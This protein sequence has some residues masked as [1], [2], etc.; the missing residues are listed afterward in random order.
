[1][2]TGHRRGPALGWLTPLMPL[3]WR[4]AGWTFP[5]MLGGVTP[6]RLLALG[7][8]VMLGAQLPDA[9]VAGP[10]VS[11]V[12]A[13]GNCD[14]PSSA[15]TARAFRALLAPRLGAALQSEVASA[16]PLGGLATRSLTDVQH[17]VTDARAE[18][19]RGRVAQAVAALETLAVDVTRLPP[20]DERWATERDVWTLLAQ[21]RAK[22]S[23]TSAEAAL[24]HIYRVD[25][26]YHPDKGLY[27]PSFQKLAERVRKQQARAPTNRLDVAVSPPGTDLYVDGRKLGT[28]PVTL[29]LPAGTYRIEAGFARRS[30]VRSVQVPPPPDLAPPVELGAE[31]E[32][33]LFADGGPCVEPGNE[34]AA[35]LARAAALLA[36]GRLLAVHGEAPADRRV[37]V[38]DEVTSNGAEVRQARAKL[39]PG[40]PETEALAGLAELVVSGKVV[41]GVELKDGGQKAPGSGGGEGR[42]QGQLLGTPAPGGFTFEAYGIDPRVAHASLHL[43]GNRFELAELPAHRTVIH[44]VTDDG[45]VAL[46]VAE[47]AHGETRMDLTLEQPCWVTGKVYDEAGR[48]VFGARVFAAVR[49]SGAWRATRTGPRGHFAFR[50]LVRGDY[51]LLAGAGRGRLSVARFTLSGTCRTEL[52]V[53]VV[54]RLALASDQEADA[55]TRP[56]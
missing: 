24:A 7:A 42:L 29:R 41:G 49:S 23:S 21:A 9:G 47:G 6:S 30:L 38:L 36:V 16:A 8:S 56:P 19:Y 28:A 31:V 15:I 22:S 33:S 25:P 37:L 2:V 20:T 52:P 34:R 11:A 5:A 12:V 10:Q 1:M 44:V 18:F 43:K 14:A 45:R 17:A 4:K 27:P 3:R 51:E 48:P 46:D 53:V 54:P 50:D 55:G 40:A 32:G 13:L 35:A 39:G 26:D